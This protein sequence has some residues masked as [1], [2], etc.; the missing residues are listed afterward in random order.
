M[1][2]GWALWLSVVTLSNSCDALKALGALDAGWPFASGNYAAIQTAMALYSLPGWLMALTYLVVIVW[3]A[4]A[5]ALLWWAAA[6]F[7]GASPRGLG[8][9]YLACGALIG[10]WF[11]FMAMDEVFLQYALGEVHR[12]LLIGSIVTPLAVALLPE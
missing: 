10:L 9:V 7:R 5:A 6:R 4:G 8:A 3:E 11:A 1:I 12:Q 2:A